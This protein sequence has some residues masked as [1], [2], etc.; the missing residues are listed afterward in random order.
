[1]PNIELNTWLYKQLT[2]LDYR[3]RDIEQAIVLSGLGRGDVERELCRMREA[4]ENAAVLVR[5]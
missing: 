5:H 4:V 3:V 2:Q 1:M